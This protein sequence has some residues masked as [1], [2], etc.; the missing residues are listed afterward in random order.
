M[1]ALTALYRQQGPSEDTVFLAAKELTRHYALGARA[2]GR[3]VV[4]G[5]IV[6]GAS[7]AP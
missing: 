6:W 7:G 4:W 1:A 3:V 5:V 2:A